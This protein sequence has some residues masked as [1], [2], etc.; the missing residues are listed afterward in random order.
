MPRMT[1]RKKTKQEP[2]S[3]RGWRL[4]FITNRPNGRQPIWQADNNDVRDR[5][6]ISGVTR[7]D[8]LDGVDEYIEELEKHGT[9]HTLDDG[10]RDAALRA[11]REIGDRATLDEI[12]KFWKDRHPND[13]NKVKL[14]DAVDQ[15]LAQ[16]EREKNRPAT[17]REIRQKLAT[18]KEWAGEA[19]PVAAIL[20]DD[21]KRFVQERK[22][23]DVSIRAWKKVLG[24]FFG[25]QV[26][27]K[28]IVTN[29]VNKQ[30]VVLPKLPKKL[31]A[32]W[33]ARD[34]EAF[35]RL[36][37]QDCPDMAAAFAVLWWAGLRPT[38]LAGQYGLEHEKI[39]DAKSK[40][41]QART[42]YEAERMRLGLGQGRGGNVQAKAAAQARL[43]ASEQA[44]AL[45]DARE[46][47]A[48]MHERH[49]GGAMQGLQWSDICLDDDDKFIRIRAE[50]SKTG[51][52]RTVEISPN[53][54]AWLRKYRK[55]AG[56]F[57]ANPMAFRRARARILSKM[58]AT[59]TADVCRHTFAS[60]HYKAHLNRDRLAEAMGH[61]ANSRQIELH[62]KN[63]LVGKADT[64]LFWEIVPEGASLEGQAQKR[65]ARKGA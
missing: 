14:A 59:W 65:T 20:D 43:D 38:E 21:I 64:K 60:Y 30:S 47:L 23:G 24:A 50:T 28:A 63:P 39:T 35:M 11:V 45:D 27:I 49:G 36:V 25:Y 26:E 48:K 18:F 10:A 51:N 58:S 42:N 33:L 13:G 29:P 3:Y 4:R 1:T 37:E 40:L 46:H 56:P 62:Y 55:I 57:V 32:F 19:T 31:P 41:A 16:R 6:R 52:P 54:E 2:E 34:V 17:I 12:V 5:K 7:K 44:K 15:F 22:V 9:V 61:S 53:L 8:V